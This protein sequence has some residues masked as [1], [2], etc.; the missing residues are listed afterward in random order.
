MDPTEEHLAGMHEGGLACPDCIT[1]ARKGW[2][3]EGF[4]DTALID[5]KVRAVVA[6][7]TSTNCEYGCPYGT[8][9][10]EWRLVEWERTGQW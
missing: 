10:H 8:Y 7:R 3:D 2:L 4:D 6:E 5:P 1:C 9:E